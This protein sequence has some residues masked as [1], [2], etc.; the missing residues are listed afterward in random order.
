MVHAARVSGK[1]RV[2]EARAAEPT[3]VDWLVAYCP[4]VKTVGDDPA[5]RPALFTA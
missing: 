2:D 3:L 4:Q 5:L 1:R